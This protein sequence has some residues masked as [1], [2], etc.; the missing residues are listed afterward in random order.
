MGRK[1]C[2]CAVRRN[3]VGHRYSRRGTLVTPS[4]VLR[5]YKSTNRGDHTASTLSLRLRAKITEA[6]FGF[7]KKGHLARLQRATAPFG[8]YERTVCKAALPVNSVK[9]P[10]RVRADLQFLGFLH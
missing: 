5:A 1:M 8:S 2:G 6:T 7:P 4:E 10:Q 9:S 3:V